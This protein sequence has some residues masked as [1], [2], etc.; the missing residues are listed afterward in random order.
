MGTGDQITHLEKKVIK[1]KT[2]IP[3][4]LW[5]VPW[6]QGFEHKTCP[7]MTEKTISINVLPICTV[8][9]L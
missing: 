2:S 9:K 8:I 7:D 4:Y 5:T 3:M 1:Q 6:L